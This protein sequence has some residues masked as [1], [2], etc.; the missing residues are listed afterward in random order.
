MSRATKRPAAGGD[1]D[2]PSG[3]SFV[4]RVVRH[5]GGEIVIEIDVHQA[6]AWSI[7]DEVEVEDAEGNIV[8]ASVDRARTTAERIAAGQTLRLV[9]LVGA[10]GRRGARAGEFGGLEILV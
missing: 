5:K 10:P 1:G 8:K 6:G 9:L 4:G 2:A 7:E 3:P